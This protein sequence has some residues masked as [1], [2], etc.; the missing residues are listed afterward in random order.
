MLSRSI[1]IFAA[2]SIL[3]I[4]NVPFRFLLLFVIKLG[5][6]SLVQ[7]VAPSNSSVFHNSRIGRLGAWFESLH[8]L[9]LLSMHPPP[10]PTTT[11]HTHSS[12]S[13]L[14]SVSVSVCLSTEP[15]D[16]LSCPLC[17]CGED[18]EIHFLFVC[19]ATEALR[20]KLLPQVYFQDWRKQLTILNDTEHMTN[21][22]RYINIIA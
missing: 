13:V 17:K 15:S 21:V 1:C 3:S 10:P 5:L 19:K 11:T 20:S 2:F 12:L 9:M 6:S 4:V 22:A 14:G 18:D 7:H 16:D 8:I